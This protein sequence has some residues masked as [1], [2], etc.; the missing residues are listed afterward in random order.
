MNTWR[1]TNVEHA[2]QTLIVDQISRSW[3]AIYTY[4]YIYHHW[5]RESP[6]KSQRLKLE[7]SIISSLRRRVDLKNKNCLSLQVGRVWHPHVFHK[8]HMH[9][10]ERLRPFN[11]FHVDLSTSF[12]WQRRLEL[13]QQVCSQ[14]ETGMFGSFC[15]KQH[16]TQ[17]KQH[18]TTNMSI[19]HN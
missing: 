11:P 7:T 10:S 4:I 13:E 15:R 6:R 3:R 19:S 12:S 9:T 1:H 18:S 5:A 8:A 17:K 14:L 16:H 2:T